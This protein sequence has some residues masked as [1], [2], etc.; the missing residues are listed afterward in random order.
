MNVELILFAKTPE[1][2]RAKTRLIPALGQAGAARLAA[3]LIEDS[4]RRSIQAWPGT[5]RLQAWPDPDHECFVALQRRYGIAVSRQAPDHLGAKM[6]AAL[7]EAH[8]RG[9]AAAI[10]GCD[11]PQCPAG[12]LRDAHARLSRNRNIIGPSEDGGY[13]LIGINPPAPRCFE[14]IEWGGS[15]VLADTLERAGEAGIELDLLPRLN[16]IDT[17]ADLEALRA[18]HPGLVERLLSASA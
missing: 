8:S 2:G 11:V 4:V 9:V 18:T 17:I 16:D 12:I 7:N 5:V 1:A 14:G 15:G 10:M 6:L 3:A 13:Y